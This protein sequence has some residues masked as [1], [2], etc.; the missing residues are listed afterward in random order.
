MMFFK[1]DFLPSPEGV[2]KISLSIVL[3]EALKKDV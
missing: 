1:I 3:V 2:A